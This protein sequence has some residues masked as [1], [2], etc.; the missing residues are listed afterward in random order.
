[1]TTTFA[2]ALRNITPVIL[3][4]LLISCPRNVNAVDDPDHEFVLKERRTTFDDKGMKTVRVHNRIKLLRK[5]AIER[6]GDISFSYNSF[7]E[8]AK[9][10]SAFTERAGG[11]KVMV[12]SNI[13]QD[14]MPP[15]FEE[16]QM[17][18]DVRS[19]A[20][21]MPA[22][23]E[24]VILDYEVETKSKKSVISGQVWDEHNLDEMAPVKTSVYV[25][26]Y[27]KS[28]K[29]S[30]HAR[31][32]TNAPTITEKDGIISRKWVAT[33]MPAIKYEAGMPPLTEAFASIH[34]SSVPS[35]DAIGKW[36]LGLSQGKDTLNDEI[37]KQV[38][39]AVKG[40]TAVTNKIR[41]IL[42]EVQKEVRY[43]GI[44]LG[45][46]AY[47][48]HAATD[49][50]QNRYGDCKDQSTLL[51]GMLKHAGIPAHVALLKPSYFGGL[52]KDV[53]CPAQ[54]SH[55]I[56]RVPAS[57][58]KSLWL[59]PTV[60][61]ADEVSF[62]EALDGVETLVP[63]PAGSKFITI[64]P[65]PAEMDRVVE[66][67]EIKMRYDG[68]CRV[69][70]VTE[71]H[72]RAASRTRETYEGI[73]KEEW[74]KDLDERIEET[75]GRE[76]LI[77]FGHSDPHNVSQ[78]F[79]VWTEYES[80][81]FMQKT[82]QGF[83][84][85]IPVDSL[86]WLLNMGDYSD[87]RARNVR[88][89]NWTRKH[90]STRELI[91][92]VNLPQ[93]FRIAGEQRNMTRDFRNGSIT[94]SLTNRADSVEAYARAVA[95]AC[96]V[97]AD[98]WLAAK[99][100]TERGLTASAL[101]LVLEDEVMKLITDSRL[102]EAR[103]LLDRWIAA[104]PKD[105]QLH[106]R[107]AQLFHMSTRLTWARREYRKA[108]ELDPDL[109]PAYAGLAET[110]GG[111]GGSYGQGFDREK[112]E[113]VLREAAAKAK[114]KR[115][116][117][118]EL[119]RVLQLSDNG[120]ELGD[121][122]HL[123]RAETLCREMV[124]DDPKDTLALMHLGDCL[125]G[126]NK[127]DDAE[128]AYA[129]AFDINNQSIG[130][131]MGRWTCA[132][133]R[134]N[135]DEAID[136]IQSLL[137]SAE[138][139]LGQIDR[140]IMI[141]MGKRKYKEV[142][143]LIE[144]KLSLAQAKARIDDD[145]QEI[146]RKLA[147]MT[148]PDY[149]KFD[150]LTSPKKAAITWLAGMANQDTG[151]VQRSMSPRINLSN[152]EC[153]TM[154]L[155]YKSVLGQADMEWAVQLGL[156]MLMN[157]WETA[158]TRTEN[159]DTELKLN[160]PKNIA[161]LSAGMDKL[162]FLLK[163]DGKEYRICYAGRKNED[164]FLLSRMA[165]SYLDQDDMKG[166]SFY[167][168][169]L[170]RYTP[171]AWALE[172]ELPD[173]VGDIQKDPPAD[174]TARIYALTGAGLLSG[175]DADKA[176]LY[177]SKAANIEKTNIPIMSA[178]AAAHM[179]NGRY[180]NAVELLKQVRI[181]KPRDK[182][183]TASL[184]RALGRTRQ[185]A[186][187]IRLAEEYQEKNPSA[188][189]AG[190]MKVS[191][192]MDAGRLEDALNELVKIKDDLPVPVYMGFRGRICGLLGQKAELKELAREDM[193]GLGAGRMRDGVASGFVSAGD[194]D[195][196]VEQ[197]EAIAC[198][199]MLTTDTLCELGRLWL[200]KGDLE[201]AQDIVRRLKLFPIIAGGTH[202]HLADLQLSLGSYR[203]SVESYFRAV[204]FADRNDDEYR[205]IF[206]GIGFLLGGRKKGAM[207]EFKAAAEMCPAARWP[208]PAIQYMQGKQTFEA[209]LATANAETNPLHKRQFIAELMFY[210]GVMA[211]ADGKKETAKGL[212]QKCMD[213]N[214]FFTVEAMMAKGLMSL[215]SSDKPDSSP[216]AKTPEPP[217]AV[218]P[219]AGKPVGKG[220]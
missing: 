53:P 76:R 152:E 54:F 204:R 131:I 50:W 168:D 39:A 28:L 15:N 141:L 37:R 220:M 61:Y 74:K 166:A 125:M 123:K 35:W 68:M 191:C 212:F 114:D 84:C 124:K 16:Y 87:K 209:A 75:E 163:P 32:F 183:A 187:A 214:A 188:K 106:T 203:D 103:A 18:S 199:R 89:Y 142:A 128:A 116:A 17:Y 190:I 94:V 86:K 148:K 55:A 205:H 36:Y 158:E 90:D 127:V 60:G 211:L 151:R 1:M 197:L 44:E 175:G 200:L 109:V 2:C 25:I 133:Y 59:D 129:Q 92:R 64:A 21:S 210:G 77:D 145:T 201:E 135:I 4:S 193:K 189:D 171:A 126:Q 95:K 174:R 206:T 137:P 172:A 58:G 170:S 66:L 10:I 26:Q 207:D 99:N 22:L 143:D 215:P 154:I 20:F 49:V 80:D 196:A 115:K 118:L 71:Y 31:N 102:R 182:T 19:L 108:V 178:L 159:G 213:A 153:K 88:K 192:M 97:P 5:S 147:D 121:G 11:Q 85:A 105:A 40:Q 38:D 165:S 122:P 177:L 101:S 24:G 43:V 78:P 181:A 41:A 13:V 176:V 98:E 167:A 208:G 186:Q 30:F 162:L 7:Y 14:T 184:V 136:M 51:V 9:L 8:Q 198:G 34:A 82:A 42:H 111:Y 72:G 218:K 216:S 132:A 79:K 57:D 93:G 29:L 179:R 219:A 217:A 23:K 202:R 149:K 140:L 160:A 134:G 169:R 46:S 107:L 161:G 119:L 139:Q 185:Y 6:Q 117:R 138:G 27:P 81:N 48:P 157:L 3:I 112:A 180:D 91:Y 83:S 195:S 155:A 156:D 113:A 164:V 144:R 47:E 173:P 73:S 110:W 12:S 63:D 65:L 52:V 150:D 100:E 33:D 194:F 62:P 96:V 56:V 130:A 120:S 70:Q 67:H 104:S 146:F 69:K 45:Q